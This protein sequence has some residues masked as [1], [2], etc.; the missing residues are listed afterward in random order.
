MCIAIIAMFILITSHYTTLI[1]YNYGILE[2]R[3]DV[4]INKYME[5]GQYTSAASGVQEEP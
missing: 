1:Y 5:R 4:Y 2:Q 3:G